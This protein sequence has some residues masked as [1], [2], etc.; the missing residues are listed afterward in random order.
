M[1]GNELLAQSVR[2]IVFKELSGYDTIMTYCEG[3]TRFMNIKDLKKIKRIAEE[4]ARS[5]G[6][7]L[8]DGLLKDFKISY[9]GAVDLVTEIDMAS[10]DLIVNIIKQRFPDHLIL[11]EEGHRDEKGSGYKWIIDP[12]DGTTN[13]AHRFPFFCVSIGVE[14]DGEVMFGIVYDPLRDEAFTAEKGKGTYLNNKVISVS[15][16]ARLADSLLVTGF[17]YDVRESARNNFNHFY[18]FSL[19]SIGVRRTGSA[20]LDLCYV[21]SGR[22]DGFWEMNLS[23]WDTAAG[24]LIVREAGGK[25]TDFSG[26]MF[27]IYSREILASNSKIHEEMVDILRKDIK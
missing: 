25:V 26:G 24:Y 23:P 13:Y 14:V 21:A 16:T 5:A 20:A 6:D 15:T 7:L 27:S 17:A 11:A 1:M 19:K 3:I 8:R 22:L 12:L 4:A 10:E 2:I 18:N 9:K